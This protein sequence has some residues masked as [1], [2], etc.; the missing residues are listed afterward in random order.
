MLQ[1]ERQEVRIQKKNPEE[2]GGSVRSTRPEEAVKGKQRWKVA[3]VQQRRKRWRREV[4][5][6]LIPSEEEERRIR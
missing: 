1:D 3:A 5:T 4:K 6:F 2:E